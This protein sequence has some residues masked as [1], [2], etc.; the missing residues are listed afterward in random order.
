VGAIGLSLADRV[1]ELRLNEIGP[2]SLCGLQLG[3]DALDPTTRARLSVHPGLAGEQAAIARGADV[4]IVDPPRKG[5]DAALLAELQDAPPARLIYVSCGLESLL[6]DA[7]ALTGD[8]LRLA[9]LEAFDL[10]PYTGHVE[11]LAAFDRL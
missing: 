11:T 5:L 2:S 10:M 8:G 7:A 4:V 9:G 1:G 3:L 6:A